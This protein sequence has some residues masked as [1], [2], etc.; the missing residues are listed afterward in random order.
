MVNK[1]IE[2]FYILHYNCGKK[3]F[4]KIGERLNMVAEGVKGLKV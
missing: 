4:N 2:H 3:L 1:F